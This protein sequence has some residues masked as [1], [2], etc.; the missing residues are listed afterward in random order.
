M[1]SFEIGYRGIIKNKL[2]IDAYTY[3]GNYED[4]IGRIGLYQPATGEAF[5]IT[6]N[7]SNKVKTYGFGL[8]MDYR[9]KNNYS[10]FFNAYSDVITDVPSGFNA[11]F[12]TPKYRFNAGIANS[13]LGQKRINQF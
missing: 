10:L 11:Y 5:S 6:A 8:G 3:F 4:F 9:L 13:G 1:R 12:N 7:S 2:M